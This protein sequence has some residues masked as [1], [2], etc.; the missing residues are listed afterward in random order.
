MYIFYNDAELISTYGILLSSQPEIPFPER[1]IS[2]VSVPGRDGDLFIDNGSYKDIKIKMNFVFAAPMND[3]LA[4]YFSIANFL[5]VTG[6]DRL[7]FSTDVGHHYR[8]KNI[9][10]GPLVKESRMDNKFTVTFICDPFRY[11]NHGLAPTSARKPV[12]NYLVSKPIY[13]FKGMGQLTFTINGTRIVKNVGGEL[14]IDT[15]AQIAH[16]AGVPV[17]IPA[18]FEQ[19]YLQ[20][21]ENTMTVTSGFTLE[22]LPNWR[23]L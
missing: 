7:S 3:A 22:Y 4:K 23:T 10:V 20:P 6:G 15:D 18:E 8:V 21:G 12:N 9:T 1:D 5:V 11:L 13:T 14:V 17:S 19:L 2:S 16:S